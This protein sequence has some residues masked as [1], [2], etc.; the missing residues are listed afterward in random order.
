MIMSPADIPVLLL[1]YKRVDSV[2]TLIDL[3]RVI[4]TKN[5]YFA[6]NAPRNSKEKEITDE[7]RSLKSLIDWDCSVVEFFKITHLDVKHSIVSSIDQFFENVEFG[8]ILEDDCIPSRDFF[9]YVAD[10][11]N[12]CYSN[13][14]P[15][16]I[17]G[18]NFDELTTYRK[19]RLS[20]YCHIWGWASNRSLWTYYDKDLLRLT[21]FSTV[22]NWFF[23]NNRFNFKERIYWYGI[24]L[25]VKYN[26]IVTWDYQLIFTMWENNL[27]SILPN[28]NLVHNIG[29]NSDATNTNSSK[30][31][32]YTNEIGNYVPVNLSILEYEPFYDRLISKRHYQ[33]TLFN[34]TY[35]FFKSAV[36]VLLLLI[37]KFR[38]SYKK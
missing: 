20:K 31:S 21:D 38:I 33:I 12:Q 25:N 9:Q 18:D 17:S 15:I 32:H 23:S 29:F 13:N 34:S 19:A 14:Y 3:L 7:V 1:T 2:V 24:L 36:K 26:F 27:Y 28:S 8:I 6:N 30:S 16:F 4:G 10:T 35:L 5:I 11:Y 22:Y 37:F